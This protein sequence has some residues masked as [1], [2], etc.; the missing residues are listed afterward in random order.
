MSPEFQIPLIH[1]D[2]SGSA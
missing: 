2:Y 1:L